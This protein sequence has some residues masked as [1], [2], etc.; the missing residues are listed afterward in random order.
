MH[1][2]REMCVNRLVYCSNIREPTYILAK[3]EN[4][5]AHK[6]ELSIET[7]IPNDNEQQEL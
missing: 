7:K 4:D 2:A 5:W 3:E 1:D 6:S